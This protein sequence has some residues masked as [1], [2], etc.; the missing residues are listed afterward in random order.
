MKIPPIPGP[1]LK[2]APEACAGEVEVQPELITWD[3]ICKGDVADLADGGAEL[4]EP[5]GDAELVGRVKVFERLRA[6]RA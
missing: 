2:V 4:D 3:R 6:D 1:A 5:V